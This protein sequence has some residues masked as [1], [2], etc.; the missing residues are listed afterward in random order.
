MPTDTFTILRRPGRYHPLAVLGEGAVWIVE[1]VFD[2]RL[3]RIV[4]RKTLRFNVAKDED[5][6]RIFVNES[7][8][9]GHL[10]H[11]NI[12]DFRS[13]AAEFPIESFAAGGIIFSE[14]DAGAAADVIVEGG[15]EIWTEAG[16]E[17]RVLN[18]NLPGE[19]F[20]ELALL[21]EMPRSASASALTETTIRATRAAHERDRTPARLGIGR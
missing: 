3:G 14:G 15:V 8:L 5:S 1:R 4:A 20:G 11:A 16:G 6:L 18:R 13:T 7:E 9:L 19:A 21:R 12:I 17:R 10:D 2:A